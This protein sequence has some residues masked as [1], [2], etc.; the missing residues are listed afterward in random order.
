MVK[1]IGL[2]LAVVAL[3]VAGAEALS[4][5][6]DMFSKCEIKCCPYNTRVF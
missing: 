3:Y 2:L 4:E 6:F 1:F 5:F